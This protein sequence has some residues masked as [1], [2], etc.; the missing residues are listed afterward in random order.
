MK[1]IS[2]LCLGSCLFFLTGCPD[3]GIVCQAGTERCGQTCIDPSAD[4]KNCGMCGSACRSGQVCQGGTCQCG[5]GT[6]LCDGECVLLETDP[7]N[8]GGCGPSFRCGAGQVCENA[9]CKLSC[10]ITGA[11]AVCGAAC[12]NT[13]TDPNNCGGC[14]VACNTDGGAQVCSATDA[15]VGACLAN[16]TGT[17]TRCGSSCVQLQSDRDHCNACGNACA[18]LEVCTAGACMCGP[19]STKCGTAC[20]NTATSAQHCGACNNACE[21]SQTCHNGKCA[22]DLVAACFS[23]G[24]VV[25]LEAKSEFK[26]PLEPMGTGPQSMV[27]LDDTLLTVDGIDRKVYQGRMAS[28]GGHAF[29]RVGL[30]VNTGSAPNQIIADRPYVYLVN[31]STGSLQVLRSFGAA[32]PDGGPTGDGGL[33]LATIAETTLGMNT[34]PQGLVKLGTHLWI[35]LYGGFGATDALAGQKVVQVDVSNPAVP[36]A[37][38]AV[39]LASIDLKPFDGGTPVAR[40]YAITAHNTPD[41]GFIYVALNNLNPDTY[42]PEGPGLIAKINP[43]TATVVKVIDLGGT[44]CLNPGWIVPVG[45]KL[46]VS[47]IG[48]AEYSGP[49]NFSLIRTVRAGVRLI[50]ENDNPVAMWSPACPNAADGGPGCTPILPSRFAVSGNRIYLGDQNGGRLFVLEVNGN[51]IGER[52]G[53]FGDAGAAITACTPDMTTGIANVSDVLAVP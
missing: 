15:G 37:L 53:Y 19:G 26:G 24:Q 46:A 48:A 8:C 45:T 9:T 4:S 23:S 25:G 3:T 31:S 43:A 30:P 51:S 16:C 11:T 34:F 33:A 39:S 36:Y 35:P 2:I 50:D 5:S 20:V 28:V 38:T 22:Y 42:V 52:R 49:P 29:G 14:G 40:P 41:G 27:A 21:N 12:V 44:T 10:P 47:C 18:A 7:K 1:S 13:K 17:Q 32:L 6:V